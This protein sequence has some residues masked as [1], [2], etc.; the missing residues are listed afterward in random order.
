LPNRKP[1]TE[2]RRPKKE[3]LDSFLLHRGLTDSRVRAQA[4]ILAGRV[5]VDGVPVTKA[6][7]LVATARR[8]RSS[9]R[10]IRIR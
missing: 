7:A 10:R 3:R 8:W 5:L 2:N 1:K 6:G 9:L 4:L